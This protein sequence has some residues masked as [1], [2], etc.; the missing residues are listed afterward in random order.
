MK[1]STLRKTYSVSMFWN[2]RSID[3][4]TKV[5]T[6]S[7]TVNLPRQQFR[8]ALKLSSTKADFELALSSGRKLDDTVKELRQALIDY[9]TKAEAILERLKEPSKESFIR[10]FK[11]ET[12]LFLSNK[13]DVHFFYLSKMEELLK[14]GKIGTRKWFIQ[15]RNCLVRYAP[16]VVFEEID[17]KWLKDYH[18]YMKQR[19]NSD[20]TCAMKLR[21]LKIICNIAKA[22]G[23]ISESFNPF[24]NI[25][26]G[27][28]GTSKDVLYPPQLKQL[29]EYQT[30]GIREG[31]AKAFF[32]FCYL[33]NGMNF[34]DM[35]LLKYKDIK[36]DSFTFIREKTKA[37]M[38][39]GGKII[40]VYLHDEMKK[41]IEQWG[42]KSKAPD[43][44]VFP[45]LVKGSTLLKQEADKWRY[46]RVAN[47]MLTRIGKELGFD[48]HL[49]INLA[50]HSFATTLKLSG[51]PVSF[52]SDAL[53]H[54]NSKTTEHYMKS[55]PDENLQ[56]LSAQLLKFA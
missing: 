31:R 50:R 28:S 1:N 2:T 47:E 11:A 4:K 29:F 20:S 36:G 33:G 7:L 8:V 45:V 13:T 27:A 56:H 41:I 34:K 12:D 16:K 15:C 39:D 42:N 25:K 18:S 43:D 3:L 48:V 9:T 38:K 40:N 54:T 49:C 6:I 46:K 51:T 30:K 5:S 24:K 22:Q 35:T 14:D 55:L 52:I 23:F 19:N 44:Y 53:G 17:E 21:C 32:F 37:R 10:L 26:L